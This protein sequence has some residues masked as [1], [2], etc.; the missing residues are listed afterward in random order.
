MNAIVVFSLGP[1]HDTI[2]WRA[3]G[4]A[5]PCGAVPLE[6]TYAQDNRPADTLV[7]HGF[8]SDDPIARE[9]ILVRN[10][11]ISEMAQFR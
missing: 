9:C 8:G 1:L 10:E 4:Q 3:G 11:A 5:L 2:D 6:I 7:L